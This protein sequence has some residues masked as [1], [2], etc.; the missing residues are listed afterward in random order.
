MSNSALLPFSL[1]ELPKLSLLRGEEESHKE[2]EEVAESQRLTLIY[3]ERTDSKLKSVVM[4]LIARLLSISGLFLLSTLVPR[5]LLRLLNKLHVKLVLPW[6]TL[7]NNS[8]ATMTTTTPMT[9]L[10][11]SLPPLTNALQMTTLSETMTHPERSK[12]LTIF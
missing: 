7:S 3:P 8:S 10:T 12:P 9:V 2:E 11:A 1:L 4:T 6:Q 5:K